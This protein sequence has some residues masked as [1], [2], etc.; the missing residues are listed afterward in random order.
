MKKIAVLMAEGF[1]ESETLIIVDIL[2]RA[3][4]SCDTIYF[5]DKLVKGMHGVYVEGDQPFSDEINS[6][7]MIVLPGGR[8]GGQNLLEN[9]EVIK[10]VRKFNSENKL[11]AAMCSGT[12]VLEKA[13]VITGKQVTGYTGYADK[14]TSAHFID[15]VVVVDQNI[16]TSQGPA[17]PFPFAYKLAELLGKDT[18]TLRERMLYPFAGGK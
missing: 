2:R 7:D 16:I 1:E 3:E 11:I 8:P 10:T 15:E 17:T 4:L 6:Y 14:L 12:V 18:E 5:G 9:E 13:D